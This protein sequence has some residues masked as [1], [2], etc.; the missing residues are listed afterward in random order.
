MYYFEYIESTFCWLCSKNKSVV[1]CRVTVIRCEWCGLLWLNQ[2]TIKHSSSKLC[3]GSYPSHS[4]ARWSP[5][6]THRCWET[7]RS[8]RLDSGRHTALRVRERTEGHVTGQVTGQVTA[9]GRGA[10][11]CR[12]CRCRCIRVCRSSCGRRWCWNTERSHRS[13]AVRTHTRRALKREE[14][15]ISFIQ[16]VLCLSM[17]PSPGYN[18]H[19][20]VWHE[21]RVMEHFWPQC[22]KTH[23]QPI[24]S[25]GG[26]S[27]NDTL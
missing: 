20:E 26:V 14:I 23:L 4:S 6:D 22:P 8:R 19:V 12:R 9:D 7:R 13:C 1:I 11:L 16:S 27:S 5:A 2:A 24:S 25:K 21:K 17:F 10:H 15:S 18:A 3:S